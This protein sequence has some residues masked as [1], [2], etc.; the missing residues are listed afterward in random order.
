MAGFRVLQELKQ[1]ITLDGVVQQADFDPIILSLIYFAPPTRPSDKHQNSVGPSTIT[2]APSMEDT[3]DITTLDLPYVLRFMASIHMPPSTSHLQQIASSRS[4]RLLRPTD[5]AQHYRSRLALTHSH[6]GSSALQLWADR[7]KIVQSTLALY[8]QFEE[9]PLYE[10]EVCQ[11]M[12]E[13]DILTLGRY[14]DDVIELLREG[15]NFW[16]GHRDKLILRKRQALQAYVKRWKDLGVDDEAKIVRPTPQETKD[17]CVLLRN[18]L[19]S[20]RIRPS[21]LDHWTAESPN[22]ADP[23]DLLRLLLG[24]TTCHRTPKAHPSARA[25][26]SSIIRLRNAFYLDHDIESLRK[27][28]RLITPPSD[29]YLLNDTINIGS[30]KHPKQPIPSYTNIR[31]LPPPPL[32]SAVH[33]TLLCAAHTPHHIRHILIRTYHLSLPLGPVQLGKKTRQ[34][35]RN[36]ASRAD[37]RD[38]SSWR[39]SSDPFIEN[40]DTEV[41]A[42]V[43]QKGWSGLLELLFEKWG[44]GMSVRQWNKLRGIVSGRKAKRAGEIGEADAEDEEGHDGVEP[45]VDLQAKLRE[46]DLARSVTR[47]KNILERPPRKSLHVVHVKH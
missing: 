29:L 30:T 23:F 16:M 10:R 40:R 21:S 34:Y 41:R 42:I 35:L 25:V 8:P 9:T 37:E 39:R 47:P 26:V 46:M 2:N 18:S 22:L 15:M 7:Q 19:L 33:A 5:H 4:T 38:W 17:L 43:D 28:I 3:E 6:L 1:R 31:L 32:P 12:D 13:V 11:S 44:E 36:L 45:E 24:A 27:L 20:R 14:D